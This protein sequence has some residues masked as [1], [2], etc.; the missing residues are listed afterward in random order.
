MLENCRNK[1][2]VKSCYDIITCYLLDEEAVKNFGFG[3]WSEKHWLR[4]RE[5]ISDRR[6]LFFHIP[7]KFHH[8]SSSQENKVVWNEF[9]H[10]RIVFKSLVK[11]RVRVVVSRIFLYELLI[12]HQEFCIGIIYLLLKE[13]PG[14]T[15][16]EKWFPGNSHYDISHRPLEIWTE[17]G[18]Q[19]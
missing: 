19:M 6:M 3:K 13:I 2:C 14:T 18:K 1:K 16:N 9:F 7:W 10:T 5:Y 17:A 4:E 15:H 8:H 12:S 11:D